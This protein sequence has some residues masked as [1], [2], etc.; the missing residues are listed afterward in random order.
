MDVEDEDEPIELEE[1]PSS[2]TFPPSHSV[3]PSTDFNTV[4]AAQNRCAAS[5]IAILNSYTTI[6]SQDQS[7]GSLNSEFP[8]TNT[9]VRKQE[10]RT[11]LQNT[12]TQSPR[13]YSEEFADVWSK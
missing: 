8:A 1:L 12:S 6:N 4:E 5:G 3:L 11:P 13:A 7:L 2:C 10:R 9:F